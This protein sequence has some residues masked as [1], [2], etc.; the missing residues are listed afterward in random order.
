MPADV[1]DQLR[2]LAGWLDERWM[3]V[4]PTQLRDESHLV[5]LG[6]PPR[7]GRT[8][9]ILAIAACALLVVGIVAVAVRSRDDRGEV[10]VDQPVPD[11]TD[12]EGAGWRPTPD[13]PFTD[14]ALDPQA[15][16][17][18]TGREL[19]LVGA[20]VEGFTNDHQALPAEG[21]RMFET[22]AYDPVADTWR[23]YPAP[24]VRMGGTVRAVWTGTEVLVVSSDGSTIESATSTP[25]PCTGTTG[26][27]VTVASLDPATEAWTVRAQPITEAGQVADLVWDGSRAWL[28]H[29]D[30]C[31]VAYDPVAD[32]YGEPIAPDPS[33]IVS[34][35]AGEAQ[36]PLVESA[37]LAGS[38]LHLS[39]QLTTGL[40]AVD[41]VDGSSEALGAPP[42]PPGDTIAT[43]SGI[44]RVF[45]YSEKAALLDPGT[46]RWRD[47]PKPPLAG[48][49]LSS[50]PVWT[51]SQVAVWG[52]SLITAG[53]TDPGSFTWL[54]DGALLDP[55]TG[56][57]TTIPSG[58]P[59]AAGF[60]GSAWAGDRLVVWSGGNAFGEPDGV[61][62]GMT[63]LPGRGAST[64]TDPATSA[65]A[66]IP[67]AA[68]DAERT[69]EELRALDDRATRYGV[70]V[71]GDGFRCEGSDPS[72]DALLGQFL[73][74]ARA[75]AG[76][77]GYQV[78]VW[79]GPDAADV[80][81]VPMLNDRSRLLVCVDA[82]GTIGAVING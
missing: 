44:V 68:A 39:F 19:L 3:P 53:R 67:P 34:A 75:V 9:R 41:L 18:W 47:L 29:G 49:N 2:D 21:L 16:A 35:T 13:L 65:P 60:A 4:D 76:A 50:P 66:T 43:S 27:T 73:D 80:E 28:V 64:E 51:G 78:Q 45:A 23:T 70:D 61:L 17:V 20:L 30:G 79:G 37:A 25:T 77:A 10:V 40:V 81:T 59:T 58:P 32:T 15:P 56:T 33:T 63:W 55:A 57:W 52:G 48:R 8:G 5:P 12:F 82:A 31:V 46:G 42:S 74:D 14:R 71:D 38:T 54:T 1:S 69:P 36:L 72:F 11:A 24:P 62:Q 26:A 6:D 7:P 22:P